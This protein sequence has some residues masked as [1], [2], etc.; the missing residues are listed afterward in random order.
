LHISHSSKQYLKLLS[1]CLED[2]DK[3]VKSFVKAGGAPL[4]FA[5]MKQYV[6][7]K[8]VIESGLELL[9]SLD[10]DYEKEFKRGGWT[11]LRRQLRERYPEFKKQIK[12]ISCE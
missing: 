12:E 7:Y 11:E 1:A 6:Q 4:V 8:D 3:S 10:V 2:A 9:S 5:A